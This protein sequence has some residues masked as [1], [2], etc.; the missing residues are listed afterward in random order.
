MIIVNSKIIKQASKITT[1]KTSQLKSSSK[2]TPKKLSLSK[3][4]QLS[5]K[6]NEKETV[7]IQVQDE[8]FEITVQKHFRET[9]IR[10]IYV[11]YIQLLYDLKQEKEL[12]NESI[13]NSGYL[14][15]TMILREFTNLPIPKT[16]DIKKLFQLSKN[17]INLGIVDQLLG[18]NSPFGKENID[19][20]NSILEKASDGIGKTLSELS[21]KTE[22]LEAEKNRV[23][24]DGYFS[25]LELRNFEISED[26]DLN[27]LLEVIDQLEADGKYE[28]YM[29]RLTDEEI[30]LLNKRLEILSK[31]N[32]DHIEQTV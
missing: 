17:L 32:G 1:N 23:D 10:K 5:S 30:G 22:L 12:D 16:N 28:E 2:P 19:F 8:E 25:E 11:E 26:E 15:N 18:D 3:L 29:E 7:R 13:L 9:D 21:I 31:Q 24:V 20:L 14:L 4:N 27:K 6:F